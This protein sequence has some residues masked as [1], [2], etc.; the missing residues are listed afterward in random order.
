MVSKYSLNV[1]V[2]VKLLDKTVESSHSKKKMR[3]MFIMSSNLTMPTPPQSA[4]QLTIVFC[5]NPYDRHQLKEHFWFGLNEF[6]VPLV[7]A[8]TF[9]VQA[10]DIDTLCGR[11]R[12]VILHPLGDFVAKYHVVQSPAFVGPSNFL[13]RE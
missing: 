7:P 10:I 11:G 3:P 12:N 8:S 9:K 6:H 4:R 1:S 5:I 2:N 13:S